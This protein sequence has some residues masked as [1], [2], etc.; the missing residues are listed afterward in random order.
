MLERGEFVVTCWFEVDIFEFCVDIF[1]PAG[2]A[3]AH[4]L[5]LDPLL[6]A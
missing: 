6:H 3:L 2:D 4:L 5:V 1:E